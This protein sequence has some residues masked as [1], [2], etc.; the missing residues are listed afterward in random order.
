MM[1]EYALAQALI[2]REQT[3]KW[4]KWEEL[5]HA[6]QHMTR[7][8]S[9]RSSAE[10]HGDDTREPLSPVLE[11]GGGQRRGSKNPQDGMRLVTSPSGSRRGST[12][13][14]MSSPRGKRSS[15]SSRTS[16][17]AGDRRGSLEP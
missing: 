13:S 6:E 5:K 14:N 7:H 8:H 10:E 9:R 2:H 16:S 3:R 17:S 1:R 11:K 4:E 12:T 15:V